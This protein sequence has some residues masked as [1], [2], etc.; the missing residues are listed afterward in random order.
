MKDYLHRFMMIAAAPMD[1]TEEVMESAFLNE[2]KLEILAEV[3]VMAPRGLDKI[4]KAA[5][6][7]ERK[8]GLLKTSHGLSTVMGSRKI[9]LHIAQVPERLWEQQR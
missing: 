4:M 1:I 8:L 2:L 6:L 3:L 9:R 5:Q 7:A